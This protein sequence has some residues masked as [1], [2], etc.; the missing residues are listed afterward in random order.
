MR[1]LIPLVL[2]L[3]FAGVTSACATGGL[4]SSVRKDIDR[5]MASRN[6]NYQACYGDA[7]ERDARTK[8]RI[9]LNFDVGGNRNQTKFRNVKV[10][11]STVGDPDLE[12]CVVAQARKLRLRKKATEKVA[13][14]YPIVFEPRSL[15]P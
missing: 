7:L 1:R 12:S 5:T 11:E 8:G 3:S 9:T 2:A 4:D 14:T 13:V 6:A 10:A 15:A